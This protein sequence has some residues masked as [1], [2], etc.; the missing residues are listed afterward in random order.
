MGVYTPLVSYVLHNSF[1]KY[2]QNHTSKENMENKSKYKKTKVIYD[3]TPWRTI[4]ITILVYFFPVFLFRRKDLHNGFIWVIVLCSASFLLASHQSMPVIFF[5]TI[6]NDFCLEE[7]KFECFQEGRWRYELSVGKV[8]KIDD[9]EPLN[10][11]ENIEV[12]GVEGG[13]DKFSVYFY[14]M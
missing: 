9:S 11:R 4:A 7:N 10:E 2:T 14:R 6:L 12:A 1:A 5:R 8:V 13:I 3:L